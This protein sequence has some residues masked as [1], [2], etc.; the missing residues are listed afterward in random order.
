MLNPQKTVAKVVI[1]CL[2]LSPLA[3]GGAGVA[4]ATTKPADTV[5]TVRL[6]SEAQRLDICS[7]Q[8]AALEQMSH[9]I[10]D[11]DLVTDTD[12]ALLTAAV[13]DKNISRQRFLRSYL[14]HRHAVRLIRAA[15]LLALR[16]HISQ[17]RQSFGGC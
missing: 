3:F 2:V 13:A 16:T 1:S 6:L 4:G 11:F 15:R 7:R 14:A 8:R 10:H 17:A 9:R 5:P 12:K